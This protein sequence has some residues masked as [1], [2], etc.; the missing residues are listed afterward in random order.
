MQA[1]AIRTR[2][3][4]RHSIR[5]MPSSRTNF[6]SLPSRRPRFTSPGRAVPTLQ[7]Q[8]NIL[9]SRKRH[10]T[11]CNGWD[12]GGRAVLPTVSYL[13]CR[14]A[15]STT[16]AL[17]L[18]GEPEFLRASAPFCH[19]PCSRSRVDGF[20]AALQVEFHRGGNRSW[21]SSFFP[22][23]RACGTGCSSVPLWNRDLLTSTLGAKRASSRPSAAQLHTDTSGCE[24][25]TDAVHFQRLVFFSVMCVRITTRYGLPR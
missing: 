9:F 3:R 6:I 23:G 15:A 12:R 7:V 5:H 14:P 22:C 10:R 11:C 20:L 4:P 25:L 16:P 13:S 8:A 19:G 2:S 17:K 24:D 21:M 18:S 1:P